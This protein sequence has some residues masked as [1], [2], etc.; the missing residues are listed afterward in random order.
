MPYELRAKG[1]T[2]QTFDT[3]VLP[4]QRDGPTRA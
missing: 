4:G 3:E 1:H 2:V